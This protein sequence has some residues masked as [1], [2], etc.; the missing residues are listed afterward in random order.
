MEI[1][2]KIKKIMD[3]QKI[4]ETFKKREFVLSV[5]LNTLYPQHILFQTTQEK[6][7]LLDVLKP[8]DE[9]KV[10]FNIR[11]REWT[12]PEGQVKYFVSLEVWRID[13]LSRSSFEIQTD[14]E[15]EINTE[16][17]KDDKIQTDNDNLINL[18]IENNDLPF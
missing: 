1:T 9:V 18:L 16:T 13:V 5:D 12:N 7:T 4:S 10:Y 3:V 14:K 8:N 17:T 15:T 2:G 6:C 11:G